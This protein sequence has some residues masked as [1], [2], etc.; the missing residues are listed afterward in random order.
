[1]VKR[2]ASVYVVI[3][4]ISCFV[5]CVGDF[6]VTLIIGFIFKGYDFLN[7]SESYLGRSGSPVA[8]YMRAWGV[9]F[10]LLFIIYA[11]TLRKTILSKGA[12]QLAAVW[13]IIIYGLGEG[14]GSGLFPYNHI[15]NELSLSGKLHNLF[16]GIGVTALLLLPVALWRVFPKRTFPK[17]NAYIHFVGWSG[18]LLIFVF[19]LS[20][21]DI[22]P[23]KGLWQRLFILDYYSLMMAIAIDMLVTHS[24]KNRTGV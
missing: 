23:L 24:R 5:A 6:A 18:L 8:A 17:M 4:A 7:Q 10:S 22:L 9:I 13:L 16:S 19:M 12:W 20:R 15:G 21:L 2:Y 1:M 3:A 11:W 14:M